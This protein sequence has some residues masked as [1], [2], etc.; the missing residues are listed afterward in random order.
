MEIGRKLLIYPI[1][2][3]TI[4]LDM[5]QFSMKN[6]D[7][8]H[9]KFLINLLQNY[10][11]ESLGLVLIINSSLLFNSCWYIIRPWLDPVVESKIHFIKHI[12]DLNKYID[13]SNLPKR[14]NGTQPD[15]NYTPSNEEDQ[16][17][18]NTIRKDF[19]G[20]TKAFIYH[21]QSSINYLQITLQWAKTK[22]EN[23][24]IEQRK[25]ATKQ[26]S[27]AFIQLIPYIQTKTYYH[28]IGLIN[29]PI[30]DITFENIQQEIV[31]F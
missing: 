11:A 23:S 12:D 17:M 20:K 24:I 8:Q 27:D 3:V 1:E 16:F 2:S 18:L 13:P 28:R 26:L 29:E 22:D 6:M 31:R 25:K 10:Y 19:N 7:Y 4:I 9:T 5:N 30:F 14:L 21:K 15:F